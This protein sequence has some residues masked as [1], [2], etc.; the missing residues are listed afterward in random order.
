VIKLE[1]HMTPAEKEKFGI[2]VA[3]ME[4]TYGCPPGKEDKFKELMMKCKG[5]RLER[6]SNVSNF[7]FFVEQ[8]EGVKRVY[9]GDF[10]KLG[11]SSTDVGSLAMAVGGLG[12]SPKLTASDIQK[13]GIEG[14]PWLGGRVR[15]IAVGTNEADTFHKSRYTEQPQNSRRNLP[16]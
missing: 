10:G 11:V 16:G 3:D 2:I 15:I 14:V 8:V 6:A 12:G 7:R 1:K 5:L 9:L 13:S 4:N